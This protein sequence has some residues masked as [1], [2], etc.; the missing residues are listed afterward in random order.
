MS[1]KM[2]FAGRKFWF[3]VA[4]GRPP[5]TQ[6]IKQLLHNV[7]TIE[8]IRLHWRDTLDTFDLFSAAILI[9]PL[10]KYS[11]VSCLHFC[12]LFFPA[13]PPLHL[14]PPC[15]PSQTHY[16]TLPKSPSPINLPVH[17]TPAI[18]ASPLRQVHPTVSLIFLPPP[19][20]QPLAVPSVLS[21]I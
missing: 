2:S 21:A 1:Q 6:V 7:K 10:C 19:L 4:P 5:V 15:A 16:L 8:C 20:W 12:C 17:Y 14:S 18:S 9:C 11:Q 13:L 3:Q